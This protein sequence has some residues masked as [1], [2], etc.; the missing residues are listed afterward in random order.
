MALSLG[1]E[2]MIADRSCQHCGTM[3]TPARADAR[4]C[5]GRCRVAEHRKLSVTRNR[6]DASEPELSVTASCEAPELSV[7]ESEACQ[8]YPLQDNLAPKPAPS[9]RRSPLDEMRAWLAGL[10]ATD[11]CIKWP[12]QFDAD[13]PFVTAAG[14]RN[15][16]PRMVCWIALDEAPGKRR[17]VHSCDHPWCC[18]PRHLS[19]V[20]NKGPYVIVSLPAPPASVPDAWKSKGSQFSHPIGQGEDAWIINEAAIIPLPAPIAEGLGKPDMASEI[21]RPD[22]APP[23]IIFSPEEIAVM[24]ALAEPEP[25]ASRLAAI[26]ADPIL[27]DPRWHDPIRPA[28]APIFSDDDWASTLEQ[29][30]RCRHRASA[31]KIGARS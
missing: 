25:A 19:W 9:K 30:A 1:A 26:M 13:G 2:P 29:E 28:P 17:H 20:P 3:F 10:P 31:A 5:S 21:P 12:F 18:N 7:T 15:D 4:F 14:K 22:M 24:R 8:D 23:P 11:A 6:D 27:S 16:A